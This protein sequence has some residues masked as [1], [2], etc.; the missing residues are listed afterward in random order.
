MTDGLLFSDI[1]LYYGCMELMKDTR[2]ARARAAV[3]GT[4]QHQDHLRSRKA[5]A[6]TPRLR[7]RSPPP[8]PR[9]EGPTRA[10]SLHISINYMCRA[11]GL[12]RVAAHTTAPSLSL[13]LEVSPHRAPTIVAATHVRS[14]RRS[15]S[16]R[17]SH[18]WPCSRCRCRVRARCGRSA[19]AGTRPSGRPKDATRATRRK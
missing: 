4:H 8:A 11:T 9:R 12:N 3:R 13:Q 10:G 16:R 2:L 7:S 18:L 5:L 15:R 14:Y 6:T 1:E 17:R 19:S